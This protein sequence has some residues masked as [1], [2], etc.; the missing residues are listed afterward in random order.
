MIRR[1]R[2]KLGS[3]GVDVVVTEGQGEQVCILVL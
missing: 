1:S 3:Q 2:S